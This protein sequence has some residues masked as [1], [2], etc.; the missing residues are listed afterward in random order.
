MGGPITYP[1]LRICFFD[2]RAP[3]RSSQLSAIE[4]VE[5]LEKPKLCFGFFDFFEYFDRGRNLDCN[6]LNIKIKILKIGFMAKNS[7]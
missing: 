6:A 3:T 4:K 5:L 7:D 2:G 1:S